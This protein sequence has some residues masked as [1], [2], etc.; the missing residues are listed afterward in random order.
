MR[1]HN[2]QTIIKNLIVITLLLPLILVEGNICAQE[3]TSSETPAVITP[4]NIQDLDLIHWLEQGSFSGLAA[5]Q[6]DGNLI[7]AA[8]SSGVVLF[9]RE[10]GEQS[11]FIPVGLAPT[12]L[13]ISPDGSTL[14]IV[15][16]YPT[17]ELDGFL[18]LLNYDRWIQFYTLP[19]GTKQT[20]V[21]KDLGECDG[22]NIW[23][24]AFSPDGKQLIF[25]KKHSGD[26]EDRKFCSLSLDTGKITHTLDTK[27]EVNMAISPHGDYVAVSESESDS[28]KVSIYSTADFSLVRELSIPKSAWRPELL[29]TQ[30]GRALA[31]RALSEGD[32]ETYSLH[33]WNLASGEVIYS[34][35]PTLTYIEEMG[36]QDMVT[37]FEITEDES[38]M[39]LGTQFGYVAVLDVKTGEIEKQLGPLTWTSYNP[40]GNPGGIPAFETSAMVGSILLSPDEEKIVVSEDLTTSG[41]S[42]SIHIYQMPAGSEL[43]NFHGSTTGLDEP[44]LAFSPD[45]R[46]IASAG[47]VNGEVEIYD[48]ES[49]Q[50]SM[51]LE[52]HTK[53]INQVAFSPDGKLIATCSNDRTIGLWE[54]QSGDLIQWLSG[55]QARVNRVAFST[56]SSRLVSGADDN[57]IR[58]WDSENGDLLE[59]LELG[60][61]NWRVDF[62]DILD[63]NESVI[64]RISKYP[65]PY[66]GF[67]HEQ[68][69]W[70]TR[71]GES[72]E[73][74]GGDISITQLA[75]GKKVFSGFSTNLAARIVGKLEDDGGTT[76]IS[77][78]KSPYGTGAIVSPT[79]APNLNLVISGNGFGLHSWELTDGKL[80]FLV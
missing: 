6:P 46:Q 29:F 15:I 75:K 21:I 41:Q 26:N 62:L 78:L 23:D 10:S 58:L 71:S 36:Q 32:E 12:A 70:N 47:N 43:A 9:D 42:G 35:A 45:S 17:G 59:T 79:I 31:A 73:I 27:A 67:I 63:D 61:E 77:T 51:I 5:Q 3:S 7:A 64:Y 40:V 49:G 54:A 39:Y 66:I 65:S 56:D 69:L 18:G 1:K 28:E 44:W 22:S 24:I 37:T 34:G 60:D 13:S 50:I 52:G 30:S 48:T 11:G 8:T 16:N 68:A 33:I 57:T 19:E 20:R 38:T 25:E 55:H 74:G 14:A 72:L 53:T 76:I 80:E 2:Y 4:E